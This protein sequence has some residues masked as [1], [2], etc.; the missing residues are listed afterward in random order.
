M[1]KLLKQWTLY[2]KQVEFIATFMYL[3]LNLMLL[4][5]ATIMAV[6]MYSRLK[7]N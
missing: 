7:D 1:M 2:L 3:S 4:S 5:L 6:I